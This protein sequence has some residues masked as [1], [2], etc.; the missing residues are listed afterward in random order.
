M[1][2]P[3]K[4][5]FPAELFYA[6]KTHL[7]VRHEDG[8][9]KIGLHALALET[10]GDIAYIST[11][12]AGTIIEQGQV[13]GSIEAAKM[14]DELIAP[15]SGVITA[16]NEAAERNPDLINSD[17]YQTGWI[18]A[19][20]PAAWESESTQLIHGNALDAWVNAQVE[21]LDHD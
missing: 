7:W 11:V 1:A 5:N 19:I 18:I 21:Q 17:P 13:I 12:A 10:F 20:E 6:D 14:V 9:A 15:I 8:S 3:T 16:R 4:Y 2:T